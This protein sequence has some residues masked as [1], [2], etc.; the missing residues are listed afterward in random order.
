MA[1]V[2]VKKYENPFIQ[3]RKSSAEA[4]D[5]SLG[6]TGLLTLLLARPTDWEINLTDLVN[7]KT[8]G[9]DAFRSKL[10]E[11][12]SLNYCHLF[13]IRKNGRVEDTTY[14]VL[15][16]PI[17]YE[18]I[19]NSIEK[20]VEIEEGCIL[21][22]KK[23]L[24]KIREI[25]KEDLRE[26][27]EIKEEKKLSSTCE[28]KINEKNN[29]TE[30]SIE[31]IKEIP[32]PEKPFPVKPVPEIPT[33]IIK[34][35]NNIENNNKNHDSDFDF[36]EFFKKL[37]IKFH[38]ANQE[39]VKKLLKDM[40]VKQVIDYLNELNDSIKS[41]S[42]SIINCD[43]LFTAK[44]QK[45]ERQININQ[46][47]KVLSKKIEELPS[48]KLSTKSVIDFDAKEKQFKEIE[49]A[50]KIFD[51]LAV[52]NQDKILEILKKDYLAT[53]PELQIKKIDLSTFVPFKLW[54]K[55]KLYNFLEIH[56]LIQ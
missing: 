15:E 17:P 7:R 33:L 19:K 56:N 23:P 9:R 34:D 43:G 1:I 42:S 6:A 53:M 4:S 10:N 52:D 25:N 28:T 13:E 31:N 41:S 49:I 40:S 11:L 51:N 50:K 3:I 21:Y 36:N 16:E 12:R 26:E 2:K 18:I 45:G 8:D 38:K 39:A 35:Y 29:G 47:T 54:F 27:L 22:Y 20:Y 44:L 5:M 30:K 37:G 14:L 46:Q 48:K 24:E 32:L 55:S